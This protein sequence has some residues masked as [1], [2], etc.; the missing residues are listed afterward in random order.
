MLSSLALRRGVV[1][2]EGKENGPGR[3]KRRADFSINNSTTAIPFNVSSCACCWFFFFFFFVGD[4]FSDKNFELWAII[5]VKQ[6]P[7]RLGWLD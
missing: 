1:E 3:S 4:G 7:G 6:Q 2:K 5:P